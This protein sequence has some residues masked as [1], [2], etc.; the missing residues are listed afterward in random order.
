[1]SFIK[2]LSPGF[3]TTELLY[4]GILYSPCGSTNRLLSDWPHLDYREQVLGS[5]SCHVPV[6]VLTAAVGNGGFQNHDSIRFKALETAPGGK[7]NPFVLAPLVEITGDRDRLKVAGPGVLGG[8]RRKNRHLR[9]PQSAG[10]RHAPFANLFA[11]LGEAVTQGAGL[12]DLRLVANRRA[13]GNFVRLVETSA[14]A[15]GC[16]RLS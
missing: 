5:R 2:R 15:Q 3:P 10:A 8:T 11:G 12:E 7:E 13:L 6:D 9:S 16:R 1:M 14:L 4:S